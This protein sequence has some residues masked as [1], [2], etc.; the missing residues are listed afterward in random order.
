MERWT[1]GVAG[2][3]TTEVARSINRMFSSVERPFLS[4][5]RFNHTPDKERTDVLFVILRMP[6][7]WRDTICGQFRVSHWEGGIRDVSEELVAQPMGGGLCCRR[8]IR[9]SMCQ[10]R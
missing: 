4:F 8:E 9:V 3:R 6:Q 7:N 1:E 5:F 2:E 10:L